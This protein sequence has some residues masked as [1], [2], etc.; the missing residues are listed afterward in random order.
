VC[1]HK[2]TAHDDIIEDELVY[3]AYPPENGKP[4]SFFCMYCKRVYDRRYYIRFSIVEAWVV[5]CGEDHALYTEALEWRATLVPHIK[6]SSNNR[7]ARMQWAKVA[8]EKKRLKSEQKYESR[9]EEPED[10]VIPED[11]YKRLHGDPD[12]NGLG[13]RRISLPSCPQGVVVPGR[14]VWKIKR[15]RIN[16]ASLET[17]HQ[18]NDG[19]ASALGA[20]NLQSVFNDF[21][22][23]V[24]GSR[25]TGSPMAMGEILAQGRVG[26][27]AAVPQPHAAG[28]P[29]STSSMCSSSPPSSSSSSSSSPFVFFQHGRHCST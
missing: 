20:N 15:A 3:W 11:D 18:I 1:A 26:A 21:Q 6:A 10:E 12:C 13:H 17:V 8:E 9:V 25:A 22:S 4:Q 19:F 29:P 23:T 16:S 24:F 14:K 28:A 2:D 7:S 5:A 27:A